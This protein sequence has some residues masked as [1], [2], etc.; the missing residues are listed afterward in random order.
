MKTGLTPAGVIVLVIVAVLVVAGFSGCVHTEV[1][2]PN[3]GGH[4][5]RTSFL[6]NQSVGKI[7]VRTSGSQ[8]PGVSIDSYGNNSTEVAQAALQ[9]AN[10]LAKKP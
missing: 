4:F 8:N 1:D 9:L 6:S 5:S 10:A 3:N 7:D 2:L